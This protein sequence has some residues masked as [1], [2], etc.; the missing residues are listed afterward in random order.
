MYLMLLMPQT[1][2][3]GSIVNRWQQVRIGL[4]R[5]D[6]ILEL[7]PERD[8]EDARTLP[9]PVEGR[10]ELR[11]VSMSY[12]NREPALRNVS[13]SLGRGERVG[14]VGESGA[15]KT[16]L[17]N[18]LLRFYEPDSGVITIDGI[19]VRSVQ[20]A[21]LRS[22]LALVPQDTTLFDDTIAENVRY[23]RAS[24]T[25]A[26]VEEACH[27][28]Q[29]SDFVESLPDGYQTVLSDRGMNLS[30]GQRQRL[31]IARAL[32]K[33]API[34]LMDEP[35]SSL[36][37]QTEE[38]LRRAM[39]VAMEGRTTLIIAHRLATVA[40]LPRIIVLSR[41]RI[42]ADGSHQELLETCPLYAEIVATQMMSQSPAAESAAQS[43]TVS[44]GAA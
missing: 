3:I 4:N 15:G 33:K 17:F 34:L 41:G 35:T 31:A 30:G 5:L 21:S 37:A 38:H 7:V 22:A 23:A 32:L 2:V 10:I 11:D 8:H 14:L 9:V 18:L 24:A 27:L 13:F 19:D 42:L 36:D 20:L 43:E 29:I 1:R 26:E 44:T 25:D 40:H 28:A 16:T 12:D 39:E 6:D